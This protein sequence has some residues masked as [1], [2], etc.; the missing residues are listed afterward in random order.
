MSMAIRLRGNINPPKAS[1]LFLSVFLPPLVLQVWLNH[2][3]QGVL[4]IYC[5]GREVWF[6]ASK[7]MLN[8]KE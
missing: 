4:I 8:H 3:G 6:I 5:G 1:L 2:W 7:E